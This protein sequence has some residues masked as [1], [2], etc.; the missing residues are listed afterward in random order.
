LAWNIQA[1]AIRL[2]NLAEL[3]RAIG[4]YTSAE[5]LYKQAIEISQNALPPD[6]PQTKTFKANFAI[7]QAKRD[8]G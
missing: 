2:N 4:D 8:K 5:P 6:H 3:H 7:M 1:N